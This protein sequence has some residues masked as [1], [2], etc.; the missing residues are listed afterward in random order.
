MPFLLLPFMRW[1]FCLTCVQEF[2][3]SSALT[4]WSLLSGLSAVAVGSMGGVLLSLNFKL[5]VL[6][7]FFLFLFQLHVVFIVFS[8]FSLYFVF[9]VKWASVA[10]PCIIYNIYLR[11]PAWMWL[12][13]NPSSSALLN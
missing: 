6:F 10:D 11:F 13:S 1:C 4:E 12:G 5:L 7:L 3:I 2:H 8:P 9:I